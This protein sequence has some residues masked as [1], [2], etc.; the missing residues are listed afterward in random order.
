MLVKEINVNNYITKSN[1]P[2][3]DYVIN[4][5]VGCPHA[6]KYCYACFMRIFTNHEEEWGT[7]LDVKNCDT[8]ID[9]KK[10][11][12][13]K[14][15]ISSVT[16]P[17]NPFEKKYEITRKILSELCDVD[18]SIDI[19]T[20]SDLVLRDIDILK[21]LK[22]VRVAFSINTLDEKFKK[23]MDHAP[24]I[25]RRLAALKKLH[26]EG[27]KTILF[28]SPIFPYITKWKEIIDLTKE[29]VDEYWFE[30]L[31]L[32][33]PYKKTILEYIRNEYPDIYPEYKKIY[34]E[35]NTFYWEVLSYNIEQ[36]CNEKN[37]SY[38]NYFH[39]D[40]LVRNKK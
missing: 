24:S 10:L 26:E 19:T 8:P 5:Y 23:D 9:K 3:S 11:V 1:L 35:G 15:F 18:C 30:N 16:D 21:R 14:I 34:E 17:Y 27:I 25:E 28:M 39:H 13:K 36:Y 33:F 7:F 4:P 12:G 22:D 38:Q 32:R 37:I 2:S 20:K 40:K 6:C 29:F 31:N